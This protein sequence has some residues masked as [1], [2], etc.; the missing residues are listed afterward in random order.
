MAVVLPE[1][2]RPAIRI[3]VGGRGENVMPVDGAAHQ[4]G[5]LL[6]DDLDDLLAGV[7]LR[8]DLGAERALLDRRHELLD[9]PEVDVGLE[10]REA[11]L[12]HGLVDVVLG[13][14]AVGTDVGERVLELLGEGVE[15]VAE[16][17][18]SLRRRGS[19]GAIAH[20]PIRDFPRR[21]VDDSLA[22]RARRDASCTRPG[23]P[24]APTPPPPHLH[25]PPRGRPRGLT[26]P[27]A[28]ARWAPVDFS[29]DDLTHPRLS[30]GS[31]ARV[32]AASPAS[33]S[34]STSRST[35]PTRR[36]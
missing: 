11:D 36:G 25:R 22:G 19:D 34:A 23:P 33:A 3:T 27:D 17:G 9:D 32:A 31:R 8:R 26:D 5:E 35:A 7:E 12:A 10:Q 16:Y 14:R 20:I 24:C 13:Q 4:R 29:V 1:P 6:V 28:V 15:Q 2:C 30:Q 21:T 18:A